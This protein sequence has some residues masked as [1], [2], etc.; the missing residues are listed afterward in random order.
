MDS[1][2][3]KLEDNRQILLK[4]VDQISRKVM[5]TSRFAWL[6]IVLIT[7]F[8]VICILFGRE[9]LKESNVRLDSIESKLKSR[10]EQGVYHP[11]KDLPE[12]RDEFNSRLSSVETLMEAITSMS[13]KALEQMNFIFTIVAAFFG[14][15]SI[16]FAVRQL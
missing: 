8:F 4:E 7:S 12:T 3:R 1:T 14:L 2:E 15:F 10:P 16:F 9:Y 13:S 11:P 6:S 5:R